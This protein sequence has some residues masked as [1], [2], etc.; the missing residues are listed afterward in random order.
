MIHQSLDCVETVG[1]KKHDGEI[2]SDAI[3]TGQVPRQSAHI[4]TFEPQPREL[5]TLNRSRAHD[6]TLA[7]ID[8]QNLSGRP[9]LLC[10]VESRDPMTG[11]YIEN[12]NSRVKIQMLQQ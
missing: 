3:E 4:Q 7:E 12:G 11:G 9:H 10:Q 2:A 6:L 5:L 1:T 8:G